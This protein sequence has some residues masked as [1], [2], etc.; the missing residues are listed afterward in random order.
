MTSSD[1]FSREGA[2]QD[3]LTQPD[4]GELRRGW[5]NLCAATIGIG[6]GIASYTPVSSLFFHA[7][8][9]EFGWSKAATAGAFIALPVTAVAL[10]LA[11]WLIDR[12]GVR[13]VSGLSALFV[14]VSYVCLARLGAH[15]SQFY[16]AILGLNVLGCATGPVA[17]TRLVA[18]QF[19]TQRGLALAIAQ[20]GIA[21]IAAVMPQC[22]GWM[23]A[24]HGWRSAYYFFAAATVLGVVCAQTLMQPIAN[25]RPET[26]LEGRTPKAAIASAPFWIL[27][28]AI[29]ATSTG[30][31][32]LVAQFRSVLADRG[33]DLQTTTAMLSVLAVAAML[34]R[35]VVGRML[36]LPKPG[37]SAAAIIAVAAI[38]GATLLLAPSGLI[39]TT[40]A[41]ILIGCS[42][43]AELDVMSYFCARF[44]GIRHY[45]ALYGMLSAFFYVGVATGAMSYSVIRTKTGSYNLAVMETTVLLFV[46]A[47]LLWTLQWSEPAPRSKRE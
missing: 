39:A 45:G 26:A 12:Y 7:L 27:G 6:F 9:L 5:R 21:F 29:F 40:L 23:I 19:H 3:G 13:T 11:G 32:G 20:L 34:S 8:E 10:P 31:F 42:I 36:D 22:I 24:A 35:L 44:F 14:A 2:R 38:G 1:L 47:I 37:R 46:A 15:L 17:Y 41:V 4:R 28:A 16:L 25:C 18:A 33:N 43:G 30:S